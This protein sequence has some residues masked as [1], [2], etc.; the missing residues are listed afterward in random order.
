MP[1]AESR[2]RP[3]DGRRRRLVLVTEEWSTQEEVAFVDETLDDFF[4]ALR[5]TY[6]DLGDECA[7]G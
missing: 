4:A 2:A 3:Y 1:V 7:S 5:Q 6:V